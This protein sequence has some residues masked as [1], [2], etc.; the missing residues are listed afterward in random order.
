ML[1]F[2]MKAMSIESGCVVADAVYA[3]G[4]QCGLLP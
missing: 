4:I 1:I 2:S 3:D